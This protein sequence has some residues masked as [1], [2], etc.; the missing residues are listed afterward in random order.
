[1]QRTTNYQDLFLNQ[2]RRDHQN[3]TVFLV[4]GFQIKGVVR[5]FDNFTVVMEADGRQ[6]L[7]YKHAIS[8]II[9]LRPVPLPVEAPAPQET[10]A[11]PIG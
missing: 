11:R 4:N 10:A 9:P 1:M 5:A 2:F 6:Q 8:T 7:I 3:V